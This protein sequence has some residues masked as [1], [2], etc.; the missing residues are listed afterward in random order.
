MKADCHQIRTDR[1]GHAQVSAE[2]DSEANRHTML[3]PRA[4]WEAKFAAHGAVV[5]RELLWAMQ[6][7]DTGWVQILQGAGQR[8]T[9]PELVVPDAVCLLVQDLQ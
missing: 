6:E 5:N 9:R 8:R 2:N 4:W 3:R 7:R 1:N